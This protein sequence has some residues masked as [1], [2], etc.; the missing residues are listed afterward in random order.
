MEKDPER[1]TAMV[2][3]TKK[4][5]FVFKLF[6]AGRTVSSAQQIEGAFRFALT[7]IK[8]QDPVIVGMFPKFTDQVTENVTVVKK[9]AGERAT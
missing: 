4:T 8:P 3:Q 5:C 7:H 6:G 1:M 9:I 2:R